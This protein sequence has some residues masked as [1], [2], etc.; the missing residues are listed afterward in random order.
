MSQQQELNDLIMKLRRIEGVVTKDVK[1]DLKEAAAPIISSIKGRAPV[2]TRNHTRKGIVY[3][4]G[5]LRK[6]I[7]ALPLRRT[8]N[9]VIIGPRARG[10]SPD[11]YYAPFLEFGTQFMSAK[12]FIGPAVDASFPIAERF[13][14]E[15]IKRRVDS[16]ANKNAV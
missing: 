15:L 8:K 7:Q 9:S 6:S 11:G 10:G 1:N 3:K 14:L 4:P 16:Y 12:P 2:G 13:A 5:N